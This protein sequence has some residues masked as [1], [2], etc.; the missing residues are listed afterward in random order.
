MK[1]LTKQE[2][3]RRIEKFCNAYVSYKAAADAIPCTPAQL[4]AARNDKEPPC[5]A[6]LKKIGVARQTLYVTDVEKKF[7]DG[8]MAM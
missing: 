6:I 3:L 2:V 1:V 7:L 8:S 4:S 5:P